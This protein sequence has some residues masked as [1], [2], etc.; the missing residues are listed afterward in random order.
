MGLRRAI[1]RPWIETIVTDLA[2]WREERP[3]GPLGVSA[4]STGT[5]HQPCVQAITDSLI[6]GFQTLS[7]CP[8]IVHI[9]QACARHLALHHQIVCRF[10]RSGRIQFSHAAVAR[11][12][13]DEGTQRFS[14]SA[15][16]IGWCSCLCRQHL[17]SSGTRES[18]ACRSSSNA[19]R[20]QGSFH[21]FPSRVPVG[22]VL[23]LTLA[24]IFSPC[25]A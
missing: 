7:L 6:R 18:I 25:G 10:E 14:R 5:L 16:G 11:S 15:E 3:S 23:M 19:S 20:P 22:F 9:R 1:D 12:V 2:R 13:P 4:M 17:A 8:A 21:F 24:S